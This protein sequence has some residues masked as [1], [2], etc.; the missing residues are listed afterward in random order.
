MSSCT[1]WDAY[2]HRTFAS[3]AKRWRL[4]STSQFQMDYQAQLCTNNSRASA[5]VFERI[6][7]VYKTRQRA[8]LL[9]TR[10]HVSNSRRPVFTIVTRASQLWRW[11]LLQT[12]TRR[13]HRTSDPRILKHYQTTLRWEST[14]QRSRAT[15]A[16]LSHLGPTSAPPRTALESL[17][18]GEHGPARFVQSMLRWREQQ[19][20]AVIAAA[21]PWGIIQQ[22]RPCRCCR[23]TC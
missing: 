8:T 7:S 3:T 1:D 19:E 11:M 2:R 6:S 12:E 17:L 16:V 4:C 14:F 23:H 20:G 10:H 15:L 18:E 5:N 9:A 22:Y 21:N 13:R